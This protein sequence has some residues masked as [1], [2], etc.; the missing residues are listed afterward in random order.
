MISMDALCFR[1][2]QS[3]VYENLNWQ[4]PDGSVIGLIGKN[5]TGKST[6]LRLTAGVLAEHS[7]A[8]KVDG[9]RPFDRKKE[10]LQDIFL[11]PEDIIPDHIRALEYACRYGDFYPGFSEDRFLLLCDSFEVDSLKSLAKMS[12]GQKKKAFIAF[13]LSLGVKHLLLDEPS[14]GLDIP[15]KKAL[16]DAL[17][18]YSSADR[19]L[20]VS[21]HDIHCLQEITDTTSIINPSEL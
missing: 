3:T 17:N 7:G 14:N 11:L 8:V 13:A 10:F 6:L 18:S 15:S 2:K 1:Y 9:F 19:I 20:I 16:C 12:Y 21:T 5:G 4:V